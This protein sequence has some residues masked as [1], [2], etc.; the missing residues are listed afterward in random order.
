MSLLLYLCHFIALPFPAQPFVVVWIGIR[1]NVNWL[2]VHKISGALANV[3]NAQFCRKTKVQKKT[4]SE[5]SCRD[6]FTACENDLC[7]CAQTQQKKNKKNRIA[8]KK[9]KPS[10]SFAAIHSLDF[11]TPWHD[12]QTRLWNGIALPVFNSSCN[13]VLSR[14]TC[15]ELSTSNKANGNTL[16]PFRC[17]GASLRAIISRNFFGN[18]GDGY[19][20]IS[21][22]N[23]KC[24]IAA[25]RAIFR[26][27]FTGYSSFFCVLYN[28]LELT[29][30]NGGSTEQLNGKSNTLLCFGTYLKETNETNEH[31]K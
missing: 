27:T 23:I 30:A 10:V 17:N 29:L 11:G 18:P 5:F 2:P 19:N 9:H 12:E 15:D 21:D 16:G 26:P 8:K 28:W 13:S 4:K 14:G 3:K 20:S 1:S 22:A 6:V 7:A 31:I 24:V 25:S